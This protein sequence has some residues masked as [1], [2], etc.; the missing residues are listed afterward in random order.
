MMTKHAIIQPALLDITR[1][2]LSLQ[3]C[4]VG[5]TIDYHGITASTMPLAYALA[6]QR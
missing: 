4:T 6:A 5:H 1:I 2:A 3:K